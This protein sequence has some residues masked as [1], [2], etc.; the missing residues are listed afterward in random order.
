MLGKFSLAKLGLVVGG[1]LTI[2]GFIA[3]F[4]ENATLNLVGFFYGIPLL[5][6]GLALKAAELNPAPFSKPTPPAILTLR[7]QQSTPTQTQILKDVTRYR[8]GQKV[9]LDTSLS[10]LGFSPSDEEQPFLQSIREEDIA[11]TYALILEFYSPLMPLHVWKEKR[12]KIEKFFGPG[13]R[14]EVSNP[15]EE[16]IDLALISTPEQ[17]QSS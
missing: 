7:E 6:G 8:Y 13:I 11:G 5:L 15:E 16:R 9:H 12:E 1:I 4:S 17:P 10:L 14:A 3:Y 2:I